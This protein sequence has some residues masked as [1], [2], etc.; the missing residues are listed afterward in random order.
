[1]I[2]HDPRGRH[3]HEPRPEARGRSRPFGRRSPPPEAT[4]AEA[5]FL[6]RAKEAGTPLVVELVDGTRLQGKVSYYDTAMIK[7][8]RTPGPH[9]V[10]RKRDIRHICEAPEPD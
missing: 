4:G 10:I 2:G 9:L 5:D 6:R 3:R 7:V 1:M 8:D